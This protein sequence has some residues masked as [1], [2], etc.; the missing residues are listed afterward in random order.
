MALSS[1]NANKTQIYDLISNPRRSGTIDINSFKKKHSLENRKI[2]SSKIKSK[3]PER[4]PVIVEKKENS[5]IFDID[6]NKFLVPND[7]TIGQFVYVIRKRIKLP[8]ETGIFIFVKNQ[9]PQQSI[10]MST[11]YE[12]SKDI[13][14]FLYITYTGENVFGRKL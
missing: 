3:Y 12:E 8:P 13:D 1:I 2:E 7:L 11:L 9:I 14:G 10:L 4:I 6:K 5:S